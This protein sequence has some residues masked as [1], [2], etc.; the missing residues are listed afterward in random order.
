VSSN[1]SDHCGPQAV[2]FGAGNVGRGFLGQLFSESGY[3]VVFVD[4]DER[5]VKAL[6]EDERY[7]LRLVDNESRRDLTIAPVTAV[8]ASDTDLVAD[9]ILEASIAATAV[10]AR[11]LEHIAPTLASGIARRQ[12]HGVEEALVSGRAC[13]VC[14]YSYRPHGPRVA[15]I[16]SRGAAE[17]D[18]CRALQGTASGCAGLPRACA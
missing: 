5:L 14:E 9:A 8:L 17:L 11:A 3:R 6:A 13:G 15:R 18:H 16:A 12:E 10:G 1:A 7:T 4:I 2:M